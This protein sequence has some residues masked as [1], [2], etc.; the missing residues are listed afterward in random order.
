MGSKHKVA[1]IERR[2]SDTLDLESVIDNWDTWTDRMKHYIDPAFFEGE[3]SGFEN[4]QAAHGLNTIVLG[5]HFSWL[6]PIVAIMQNEDP[7]YFMRMTVGHNAFFPGM[8][9]W[10]NNRGCIETPRMGKNRPEFFTAYKHVIIETLKKANDLWVA[11]TSGRPKGGGIEV[12]VNILRFFKVIQKLI[13]GP[14]YIVPH[15]LLW[16]NPPDHYAIPTLE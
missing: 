6:D 9:K 11:S 10:F 15:V 14:V 13:K 4:L 5:T 12:D 1:R 8:R 16:S 7:E 2:I 3:A